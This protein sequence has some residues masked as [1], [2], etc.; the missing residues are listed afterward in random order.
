MLPAPVDAATD[1]LPQNVVRLSSVDDDAYG[2]E[3]E[4]VWEIEPG[5]RIEES[6]ASLPDPNNGFD[7]A[8]TF[9]PSVPTCMQSSGGRSASSI[10]IP[11]LAML[12]VCRAHSGLVF[13]SRT[14]SWTRWSV[15]SKW[16][17]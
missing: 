1:W 17:G 13:T 16:P 10:S 9:P 15:P 5:A 2:E 7:D 6:S 14:T 11:R 4:V 3:L 8:R 12:V